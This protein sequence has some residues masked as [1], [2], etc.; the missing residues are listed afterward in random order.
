MSRPDYNRE[1]AV[2]RDTS[3]VLSRD[4]ARMAGLKGKSGPPGNMNAFKHGLAAIQKRREEGIATE[5]E[6]SV[7]QQILEGLIADK[8]GNQQISTAT[9]IFSRLDALTQEHPRAASAHIKAV[10][11][12]VSPFR[13]YFI[14]CHISGW[15]ELLEGERLLYAPTVRNGLLVIR[16]TSFINRGA[17]LNKAL[18]QAIAALP[19]KIAVL[20]VSGCI[21]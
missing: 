2:G 11:R 8:G 18:M 19:Q 14:V 16:H 21:R 17:S 20:I 7:R 10:T 13:F 1:N 5:H 4:G 6:E 15:F 9:M 12:A 3:V